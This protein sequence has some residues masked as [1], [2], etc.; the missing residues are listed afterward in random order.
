MSPRRLYLW[1]AASGPTP[2]GQVTRSGDT[3]SEPERAR[4]RGSARPAT[5]VAAGGGAPAQLGGPRGAPARR[6]TAGD[7]PEI[8][9]LQNELTTLTIFQP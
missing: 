5:P 6:K 9:R 7:S 2:A 4:T 3:G 1:T 8:V